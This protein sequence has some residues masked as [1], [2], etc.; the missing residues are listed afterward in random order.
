M[1]SKASSLIS[2]TE[3]S[4]ATKSP[5]TIIPSQVNIVTSVSSTGATPTIYSVT[6]LLL[7]PAP[8]ASGTISS[9]LLTKITPTPSVS[10]SPSVTTVT[11]TLP[12]MLELYYLNLLS[13]SLQIF[14]KHFT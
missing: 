4:P 14:L 6:T 2:V 12:G 7:T 3:V 8:S 13:H 11:I 10:A 5:T 9:K 1:T